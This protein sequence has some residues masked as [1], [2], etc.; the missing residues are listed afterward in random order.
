LSRR[1][2]AC[3]QQQRL[4]PAWKRSTSSVVLTKQRRSGTQHP[5]QADCFG[6]LA[7][8]VGA[9]DCSKPSP[10]ALLSLAGYR[11]TAASPRG[12]DR[13]PSASPANRQLTGAQGNDDVRTCK[14]CRW[15]HEAGRLAMK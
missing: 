2:Q 14:P 11:R 12:A 3:S 8:G 15:A 4:I 13:S 10:A 7:S 1:R 6:S 9:R 5:R